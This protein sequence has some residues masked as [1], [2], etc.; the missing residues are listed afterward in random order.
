MAILGALIV[1]IL[2]FALT[3]E[4]VI[5]PRTV[6]ASVNGTEIQR[7]D[8]WRYRGV[9][10]LEQVNQYSRI[11]GLV[12]SD[13]AGQYRQ[14]AAQAQADF[15]DLW[16]NTD[17]DDATLQAMIDDQ[18]FVQNLET[19]GLSITNDE[20]NAY[21]LNRFG[22][23][24]APLS[25]EIP[26]PTLIPTRAAWATE[27]AGANSTAQPTLAAPSAG[28]PTA[29]QS[30]PATPF[31]GGSSPAAAAPAPDA[32]G[33]PTVAAT[34]N[35]TEAVATAEAN[36]A[37]YRDNVFDR[38]R[39]SR[40]QYRQWV[41]EP[42]LARE[43]VTSTL[44]DQVG[45]TSEQVL[46]SHILVETEELARQI[47]AELDEPGADFAQ[48]AMNQSIDMASAE[49]G[50]DLGWFTRGQMVAPFEEA[51]FSLQAGEVSQPVQTDFGWHIIHVR[52]HVQDRPMT[53]EQIQN[54]REQ[55][56]T[57]W[58]EEQKTAADIDAD[59]TVTATAAPS[60]FEPPA[61]APPVAPTPPQAPEPPAPTTEPLP[62]PPG[63]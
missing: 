18:V 25:T 1:L 20:L 42:Q 55:A 39:I 40:E 6:L 13:Q 59:I 3:N 9:Q 21:I 45:Q 61:N 49:N 46:A 4:N 28:T 33:S 47:R 17:V 32:A 37:L 52:D 7:Q 23:E 24:D 54:A 41:A 56:V 51:A 62:E 58:L 36:Y 43:K 14:A 44:A 15:N 10:L 16:G 57:E 19:V 48:T 26:S 22:P 34:P 2:G 12:S 38:A 5:K 53:D 30:L 29:D 27:T 63:N 31:A 8:Y 35:P 60:V 11:A 50:G